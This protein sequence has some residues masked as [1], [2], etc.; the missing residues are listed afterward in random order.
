MSISDVNRQIAAFALL[1]FLQC[2]LLLAMK[3]ASQDA[4]ASGLDTAFKFSPSACIAV[5]EFIKLSLS[6]AA[7]CQDDLVKQHG[8][9]TGFWLLF[10]EHISWR[11]ASTYLALGLAYA[12]NNDLTFVLSTMADPGSIQLAKSCSP[13]FTALALWATY[14]Y[15]MNQLQWISIGFIAS[16]VLTTQID[17]CKGVPLLSLETYL[18]ML[19]SVT[20]TTFTSVVNAVTVKQ[21][22]C[23]LALQNIMLYTVGTIANSISHFT[24]F[25]S[26]A[27]FLGMDNSPAII[28][29]CLNALLG[30]AINLV[31]KWANAVVKTVASCVSMAVLVFL[32][33]FLFRAPLTVH[34][35]SGSS[36]VILAT[37]VY[38]RIAEP[39]N[40]IE[41]EQMINEQA[42]EN[43]LVHLKSIKI[44]SS[45]AN[46]TK[47]TPETLSFLGSSNSCKVGCSNSCKVLGIMAG[48]SICT[49]CTAFSRIE[50]E[51]RDEYDSG[52]RALLN[53]SVPMLLLNKK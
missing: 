30:L 7:L 51:F 49:L 34:T 31:Y 26:K 27:L 46:T 14:S 22:A 5:A 42:E 41:Q 36:V 39:M 17:S 33:A 8:L 16:G 6:S 24:R 35:A 12:L 10:S 9:Q 28:I 19:I 47:S 52:L 29:L 21:S 1:V 15:P 4:I 45:S 11:L 53:A 3:K 40:K 50:F 38:M 23:P 18:V 44:L 2:A 48:I 37:Y 13:L 32:S 20:V 43:T 25:P